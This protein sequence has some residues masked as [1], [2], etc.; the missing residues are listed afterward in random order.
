ML[1]TFHKWGVY[2]KEFFENVIDYLIDIPWKIKNFPCP[3]VYLHTDRKRNRKKLKN[4]LRQ[5]GISF[6]AY[7]LTGGKTEDAMCMSRFGLFF[8]KCYY[9]ERGTKMDTRIFLTQ[10]QACFYL[11]YS[12]LLNYRNKIELTKAEKDILNNFIYSAKGFQKING[13]SK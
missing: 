6:G 12:L 13:L 7:N 11:Y 10:S 3:L 8:W 2:T 1:Y 9:V 4:D 5:K